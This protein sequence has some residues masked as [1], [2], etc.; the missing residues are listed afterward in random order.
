MSSNPPSVRALFFS[1]HKQKVMLSL[2]EIDKPGPCVVLRANAAGKMGPV[3][4]DAIVVVSAP[5]V[6]LTGLS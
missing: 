2:F 5:V 3:V 6:T 4:V 1:F